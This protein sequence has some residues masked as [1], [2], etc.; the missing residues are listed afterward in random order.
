MAWVDYDQL[1][2]VYDRD[3]AVPLEVLEPWRVALGAYLPPASRLPVLDLGAGTGLF[4]A[5]IAQW[6][7]AEVVAVEPSEGMR[8]QHTPHVPTPGSPLSLAW[9]SSCPCGL[10]AATAP[11]CR[12]SSTTSATWP[13]APASCAA[14]SALAGGC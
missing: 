4:S 8:R 14:W 7:D 6:F 10:A 12:P 9:V 5:A 13:P 11:G 3:R 2:A 1:A